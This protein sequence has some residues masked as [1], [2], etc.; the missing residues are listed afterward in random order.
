[1]CMCRLGRT[2]ARKGIGSEEEF[3]LVRDR[4]LSTKRGAW[5][6]G[7][8]LCFRL[9]PPAQRVPSLRV[10]LRSG[11]TRGLDLAFF[12]YSSSHPKNTR[13]GLAHPRF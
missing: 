13:V 4:S 1:M 12:P 9:A 10:S 3:T 6:D 2:I 5:W 8:R 7:P 11:G